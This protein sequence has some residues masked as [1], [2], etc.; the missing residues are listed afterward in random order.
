[1]L[2]IETSNYVFYMGDAIIN[3]FENFE[4][5]KINIYILNGLIFIFS[6]FKVI[7]ELFEL[8]MDV[9][10]NDNKGTYLIVINALK[11]YYDNY[12]NL[13][14]ISSYICSLIV[15]ILFFIISS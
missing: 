5:N 10:E 2:I 7:N 15:T 11:A 14:E 13:F 6:C 4:N 12:W 3:D 8:L 1:M 9:D